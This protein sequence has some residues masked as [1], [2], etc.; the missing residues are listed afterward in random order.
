MTDGAQPAQQTWAEFVRARVRIALPTGELEV[1]PTLPGMQPSDARFPTEF[2]RRPVH[3]ITAWNP[4]GTAADDAANRA[5][6]AALLTHLTVLVGEGHVE[7]WPAV[8]FDP[9]HD[10][11]EQSVAVAGLG[12]DAACEIG[13]RYGQAAI[14][15]WTDEPDGFR[16]VACDGRRPP[17]ASPW[18]TRPAGSASPHPI[19]AHRG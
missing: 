17:S 13:R 14:F 18:F 10:W 12:R 2:A 16:V 7:L 3:V 8:G 15:E 11:H 1:G 5:A 6:Q 9:L 4:G 19:T